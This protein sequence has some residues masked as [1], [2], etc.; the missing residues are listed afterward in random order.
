MCSCLD[1]THELQ[2]CICRKNCHPILSPTCINCP[3]TMIKVNTETELKMDTPLSVSYFST[4][5]LWV[6]IRSLCK[7]PKEYA[8]FFFQ[9]N[10]IIDTFLSGKKALPRILYRHK[11]TRY[12]IYPMYWDILS[13]YHTC[14]K[15]YR[16]FYYFLICLKYCCMYRKQCRPRSDAAFCII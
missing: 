11:Y 5:N 3:L 7:A 14:P 12:R 1:D 4:K 2:G 16:P 10:E 13:A 8:N 9:R 6:F 15:I